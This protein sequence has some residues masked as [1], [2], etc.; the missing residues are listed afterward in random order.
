MKYNLVRNG[1]FDS[2]TVSGTGNVD[3]SWAQLET[4]MDGNLTS[5]GVTLTVP[6]VL[7]LEVDLSQRI[8][9]DGIRLYA[10]D[11]SK[12]ANIKF[13]YKNSENDSYSGLTTQS[14][15]SYYYTVIP[16]PSA[17]RYIKATISGIA[18]ELFEF[19][20][21]NDDY[22]VNF[23]TDGSQYSEY[24][25]N[26]PLGELGTTEAIKIFN[27]DTGSM[28]AD[29]YACVDYT[30]E[31]GDWYIKIS[32]SENG[33]Y[34]GLEDGAVI[35]DNSSTGYIWNMGKFNDT[36]AGNDYVTL[37]DMGKLGHLPN[38]SADEA[39]RTGANTWD[40]DRV[41]KKMYV[42]GLEGTALSLWDYD[43]TSDNW[44]YL[45]NLAPA[46]A[47]SDR[48][49]VMSYCDGAIYVISKYDGTFGKY[50]ISG[51]INNWTNLPNPTFGGPTPI[52]QY[53]RVSMC[54]D[55]V[56]YIYALT[57]RY[58]EES[59]NRNFR[60]FDTVSG[61][62]ASMDT[63]Y[64]QYSAVGGSS[65]YSNTS[66][67]TYDYDKDRVYLV[68]ASEKLASAGHYIQMYNVSSDS[69]GTNWF[70]VTTV[71]NTNYVVESIWYHNKWLYVSCNPYFDTGYFF[72]YNLD[73]TEVEKLN[74]GYVHYDPVQADIV[75]VYMI[76]IDNDAL[77]FGAAVYFAQISSDRK[78]LYGY[79]TASSVSGTYTT[80]V[81]KLSNQYEASYFTNEQTTTSGLS[82]ISY[83]TNSYNGTIRVRSSETAPIDIIEAYV[84]YKSST[85]AYLQKCNL[86]NGDTVSQWQAPVSFDG[87]PSSSSRGAAADRRTGH[88]AISFNNYDTGKG[89]DASSTFVVYDSRDGTQLYYK[90][91]GGEGYGFG[92]NLEFDK[93]G[94]LWGCSNDVYASTYRLAHLD[95]QLISLLADVTDSFDFIYDM[96]AEMD[97][98]GV[99]Y[100]HQ[101]NDALYHLD[102]AGNLLQ[103]IG[104]T[105]PRAICGTSDNGCW[106]GDN[107]DYYIRRYTSSG[108]LVKSINF[109]RPTYRMC[110][111]YENGFWCTSTES[112]IYHLNSV[113]TTLSTTTLANVSNL[114]PLYAGCVAHSSLNDFI[115]LINANGTVVRTIYAPSSDSGI[116]GV[117]SITYDS[118]QTYQ[119]DLLP[120]SY[121]P[122]WGTD[123]SLQWKEV[124][125]DG[126]FLPKDIYHQAEYTLSTNSIQNP[127]LESVIL[128]PVV[129]IQDIQPQSYKNMYVRTDIP[130]YV[131]IGDY[132]TGLKVW[133][134][135]EE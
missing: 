34:L 75:G 90:S 17:P 60:R 118:N 61:T 107:S 127:K 96:A 53:D 5:S 125:K 105:Q 122:V 40:W 16:T 115:A 128:S 55:G 79:N 67:L 77:D 108:T 111:D 52:E 39:F 113:G 28:P 64:L 62:W 19:Q 72:R 57:S 98:D 18:A 84:P 48:F 31:A 14:G 99:W 74:L 101:I 112:K 91:L 1:Y 71:Y 81:I 80:P 38:G 41:N 123:G 124:R 2:L 35:T 6:N 104:L 63:G 47:A 9:V 37:L 22:I 78:Y 30:G 7:Y 70:N 114:K 95:S 42:M 51:A 8:K 100:T 97:G 85:K 73:T 133:W 21:F 33:T 131:D 11:L 50:T 27:N 36:T 4:L 58:A 135:V 102:N 121:D 126:Y 45:T 86:Y 10:N 68:N 92:T 59:T 32:A 129:K 49:P 88:I 109:G 43:Y 25:D 56:R 69:W 103:S 94:G 24:L 29:A 120:I 46:V 76:A 15:A 117:L 119:T 132:E 26:T 44:N 13:Y 83:D 23:G 66:C 54:S 12:S 87:S 110:T 106:V 65:G 116:P 3:L 20:V 93:F 82:N 134:S 89:S 130:S